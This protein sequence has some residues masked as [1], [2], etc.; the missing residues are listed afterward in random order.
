MN[1]PVT[2]A[3][4]VAANGQTALADQMRTA[5][6][7]AR[8]PALCDD[9]SVSAIAEIESVST[10]LR[11]KYLLPVL[12]NMVAALRTMEHEAASADALQR[13]LDVHALSP[14]RRHHVTTLRDTARRQAELIRRSFEIL[15]HGGAV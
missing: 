11:E 6:V 13:Q 12:R 1:R 2:V 8:Q 7:V 3:D 4:Y 9:Y 15:G 10:E 14:T 5:V